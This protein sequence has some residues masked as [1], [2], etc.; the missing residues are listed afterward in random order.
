M[1]NLNDILG[2]N[3]E[4]TP[5]LHIDEEILIKLKSCNYNT[6]SDFYFFLVDKINNLD[7]TNAVLLAHCHFLMSYFLYV[8]FTPLKHESIAF[9][10]GKRA[11]SLNPSLKYK[12]WLLFFSL[13]SNN[14][15]KR[16]DLLKLCEEV[17]E[18][19]PSSEIA[20]TIMTLY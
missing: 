15:F 2:I 8:I 11:N 14:L 3:L 20:T 6:Q 19:N 17:L 10:H 9:F 16:Y 13:N 4:E 12:E 1:T 7:V 5:L 18:L